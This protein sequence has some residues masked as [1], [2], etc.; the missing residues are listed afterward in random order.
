ME[1]EGQLESWADWLQRTTAEVK[2]AMT[3]LK[4]DDW[5]T[6]VRKRQWK[7]AS[8]VV[9]HDAQRW[10]VRIL[11]W[12]PKEGVREVGRPRARWIDP[13]EKFASSWTG[14]TEASCAWMYL[15]ANA[16]EADSTL[17][18]YADYCNGVTGRYDP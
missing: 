7:W 8:Q 9:Q 1:D 5:V 18:E 11:H 3:K 13:I 4:M 17:K 15:L 16:E 12:Q 10:T 14:L 6:K 2:T